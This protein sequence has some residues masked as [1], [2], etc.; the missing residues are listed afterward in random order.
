MSDLWV[1]IGLALLPGLGNLAGGMMAEFGRTTPR[2]LNFALHAASG[3]V[4]G[5]VAIE[6]MP[7]ALDNLAGWWIAASFA[8]G[9]AAYVGAESLIEKMSTSKNGGGSSMWMIYVAVA[10]DLSSDGLMLGSG[11][12]VSFAFG[13]TL[14]AGQVL[15]DLPE[16]FATVANLRENGVPRKRR[17]MLSASF[18][19]YCVGAAL[20]AYLLL[21]GAPDAAKLAA[22]AFAA[23]LL[24]VA[25]VE[26]MLEEAHG[27]REDTRGS[28]LAFIGGFALFVLVSAGL[29]TVL[30]DDPQNEAQIEAVRSEGARAPSG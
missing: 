9:G 25:A 23:G 17:I 16:G 28:V 26:D 15:A 18:I 10:V 22:L 8:A 12:A 20:L 30:G 27:A 1:V 29:E 2:L 13:V 4:L 5:V 11:A 19:L 24:S 6:L 14:A 21:R 3:I 7:E